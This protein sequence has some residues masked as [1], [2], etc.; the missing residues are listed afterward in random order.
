M[1][2]PPSRPPCG[3]AAP[4]APAPRGEAPLRACAST[5][6][7]LSAREPTELRCTHGDFDAARVAAL[8]EAIGQGSYRVDL[9]KVADGLLAHLGALQGRTP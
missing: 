6:T 1:N 8:R 2:I 3:A 9:D 7:P 4:P 5:S